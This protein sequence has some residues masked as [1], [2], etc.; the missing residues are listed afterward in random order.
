MNPNLAVIVLAAGQGRRMKSSLP[1]VLHEVCGLP[2]AAHTLAAARALEPACLIAVVGHG[3]E[4]VRL[5]LAAPDVTFVEQTELLGTAD[6]VRRCQEAVGD[7]RR[8]L[9]LNG[10]EP[11]V[12]AE[13]LRRL[14]AASDGRSMGFIT[15]HV[16]E[17]GALGRVVRNAAG[18]VRAIVQS[19]DYAGP[20]GA[21]EINWGEYAFDGAWLW[22]NLT[23]IEKSP[24]GE[25]Y[26]TRLADFAFEQGT[27]AA[28]IQAVPEEA[29][30]VDDRVKLALAERLMRERILNRHMLNGVTIA[31]PA[32]TYIDADVTIAQDVTI[33]PNTTIARGSG[34][35]TGCRVG[36]NAILS[37]ARVGRHTTIG[38]AV[39]EDSTIGEGVIIGPFCHV[40]GNSTLG[41]G[42]H[43]GNHAEVN[44]S[45][46]GKRV[47]M[48]HFSYLGDATVGDN[49]NV[50]AGVITCNY[51]GVN[52]NPTII[53]DGA[54]VG[55]DTMLVA[56]VEMG[57]GS[58]TGAGTVLRMNLPENAKAAGVPARIIGS[59]TVS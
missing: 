28:T 49:V 16:A 14:L 44:R 43:L 21:A 23:A 26:L 15:Q 6:A 33:L 5:A 58:L 19:A 32:S 12:T 57:A 18:V 25:Y 53:G 51:D 22:E 52:K 27:P 9:V 46:L 17:G 50:A 55:C 56:P 54:F 10:D 2:M 45:R 8:V 41:D 1:K 24:K 36:P 13:T 30:G 20:A 39:V 59:R 37:N 38:A 48:R 40:R 7:A 31:D 4:Q 47:D 11:L 35:S 3:S 42:C 34:I 29:L